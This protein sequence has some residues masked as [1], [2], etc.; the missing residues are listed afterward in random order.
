[1]EDK[2]QLLDSTKTTFHFK[3]NSNTFNLLIEP[4]D[5]TLQ[6][7]ICLKWG[8]TYEASYTYDEL[9][10]H[11]ILRIYDTVDEIYELL[12]DKLVKKN[13]KVNFTDSDIS[14][15][16]E[17]FVEKTK[18]DISLKLNKQ[19][20]GDTNKIIEDLIKSN[21]QL[22]DRVF[23]LEKIVEELI[24]NKKTTISSCW[25]CRNPI[26]IEL[27]NSNEIGRDKFVFNGHWGICK[28]CESSQ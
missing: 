11:K 17:F 12:Y 1:M 24:S 15:I 4:K 25:R 9:M 23:R 8:K 19:S 14:I 28:R 13:F 18:Y 26:E 27:C 21:N 5:G 2:M 20:N 22:E 3:S 10:K 16:F 7:I 6:L